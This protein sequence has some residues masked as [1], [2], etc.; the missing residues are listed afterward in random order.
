MVGQD[1][2]FERSLSMSNEYLESWEYISARDVPAAPDPGIDVPATLPDLSGIP[3]LPLPSAIG[4]PDPASDTG[5]ENHTPVIP[6][7]PIVGTP[8][9]NPSPNSGPGLPNPDYCTVRFLNSASGYTLGV[10]IGASM[11]CPSLSFGDLT[12]YVMIPDGFRTVRLTGANGS[13]LIYL[14]KSI[15]FRAGDVITLVIVRT[16]T[17]LDLVQVGDTPCQNRPED[18]ACI[19][20][21]NMAYNA[22]GL[23]LILNGNRLVFNDVRYKENTLYKQAWPKRYQF[24]IASTIHIPTPYESDIETI[25]EMPQLLPAYILGI[26]PSIGFTLNARAGLLYTIYVIGN[27][28]RPRV[29]IVVNQG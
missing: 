24:S 22:P 6:L 17:G 23:D 3:E 1:L 20:M 25:E 26:R 11:I 2:Y 18:R 15:P 9:I 28:S 8:D 4:T 19:R 13:N 21:A 27:W 12:S 14:Q 29:K 16:A 5:D 10:R 7:P